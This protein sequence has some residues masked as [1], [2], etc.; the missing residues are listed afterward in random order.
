MPKTPATP[1]PK[2]TSIKPTNADRQL[3]HQPIAFA[4][5]ASADL[6]TV[7]ELL[8]DDPKGKSREDL[9]PEARESYKRAFKKN[10]VQGDS[11][12]FL[13]CCHVS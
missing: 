10:R 5:A 9:S 7:I 6:D 2:M 11:V 8:S 12:V 13:L 4:P 1:L 3:A